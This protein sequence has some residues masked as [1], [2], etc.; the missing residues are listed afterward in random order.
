M[1]LMT[2]MTG[3]SAPQAGSLPVSTVAGM[4][5]SGPCVSMAAAVYV[6][7]DRLCAVRDESGRMA[8]SRRRE[9]SLR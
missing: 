5:T 2:G 4:S 6:G 7:R 8:V 9:E 1:G 3:P